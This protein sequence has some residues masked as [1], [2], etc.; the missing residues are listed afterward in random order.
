MKLHLANAEMDGN[1]I[2]GFSNKSL[3][4]RVTLHAE[5]SNLR[6]WKFSSEIGVCKLCLS[7]VKE[8]GLHA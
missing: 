5:V 8:M 6:L 2:K 3:C 7:K 4:N 1:E